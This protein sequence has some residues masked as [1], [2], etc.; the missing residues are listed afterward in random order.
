VNSF[1]CWAIY[2]APVQSSNGSAAL[3]LCFTRKSSVAARD[4]WEEVDELIDFRRA[5]LLHENL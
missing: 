4:T 2:I 5:D 1:S 3:F